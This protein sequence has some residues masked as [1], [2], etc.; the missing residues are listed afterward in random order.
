MGGLRRVNRSAVLDCSLQK[1]PFESE[2]EHLS[3]GDCLLL[4]RDGGSIRR[5][6]LRELSED[7]A[8]TGPLVADGQNGIDVGSRPLY[9]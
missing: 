1:T 5:A 4:R 2:P 9:M 8:R 7:V 3:V 6:R